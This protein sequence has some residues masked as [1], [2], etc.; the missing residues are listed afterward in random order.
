MNNFKNI[1]TLDKLKASG[2]IF[3]FHKDAIQDDVKNKLIK[4]IREDKT[5]CIVSEK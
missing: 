5:L 3:R 4:Q 2:H 1:T